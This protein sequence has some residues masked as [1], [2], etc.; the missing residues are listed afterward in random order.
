MKIDAVG[1]SLYTHQNILLL[2]RGNNSVGRTHFNITMAEDLQRRD[3]GQLKIR[4]TNLD[5][6]G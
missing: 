6:V 3:F 4:K 2:L 1:R 5:S